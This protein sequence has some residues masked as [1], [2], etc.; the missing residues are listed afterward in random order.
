[1]NA[2]EVRTVIDRHGIKLWHVSVMIYTPYNRLSDWLNGRGK[3]KS[4]QFYRLG[5]YIEYLE[6][7][8]PFWEKGY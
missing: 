8:P 1:M 3:L 4:Q 6:G 2:N 7:L 5:K